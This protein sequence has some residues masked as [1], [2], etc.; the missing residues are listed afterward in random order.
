MIVQYIKWIDGIYVCGVFVIICFVFGLQV[1]VI[2]GYLGIK[3]SYV[4][5]VFV[6]VSCWL[7]VI[8]FDQCQFVE[9][10]CEVGFVLMY[11]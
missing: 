4:Y 7:V 6:Y 2:F 11:D 5:D 10:L 3:G 9:G 8:G 1:G